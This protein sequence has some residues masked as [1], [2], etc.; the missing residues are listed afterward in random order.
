MRRLLTPEWSPLLLALAGLSVTLALALALGPHV[1]AADRLF[2][3]VPT[4]TPRTAPTPTVPATGPPPQQ[5]AQPTATAT[6]SLSLVAL[7]HD[8]LPGDEL[9]FRLWLTNTSPIA[10]TGLLVADPLDPALELLEVRA[11]QG[12]AD[13]RERLLTL[14]LGTLDAGQMALVLLRTRVSDRA[15]SGQIVLNQVTVYFNGGQVTSNVAV[16]ALPPD[17]LP[18]TGTE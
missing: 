17:E 8:L 4:P 13:L 6:L 12:A 15:Q 10:I 11:T 16:A 3:T 7:P 14:D 1:Q 5:E 2:Q 18:A 9:Q